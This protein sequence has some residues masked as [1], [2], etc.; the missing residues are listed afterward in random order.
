MTWIAPLI[1][2][3]VEQGTSRGSELQTPSYLGST[4]MFGIELPEGVSMKVAKL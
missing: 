3:G 1:A 2:S 4:D